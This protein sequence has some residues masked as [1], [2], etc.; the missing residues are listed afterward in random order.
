MIK[1]IP[2]L[3]M[4]I[5]LAMAPLLAQDAVATSEEAAP[6]YRLDPTIDGILLGAAI[7][8]DLVDL[9]LDKVAK[10][11]PL[12]FDASALDLSK[13]N[14]FDRLIMNPYSKEFDYVG[15]GL[16]IVTLLTPALL[17]ATPDEEWLTIGAMYAETLLMA[18]G[19][20][21]LGK[22]CVNR[23]R[24]FMY[25]ADYPQEKVD[26]GDWN[27]SFPSGHTTLA[28]AGAAFTTYV[29]CTYLPDSNMKIPVIASSY[30]LALGTAACRL[31]S[32]NH[33]L[34]DVIVGA[35]LGTLSGLLVPWVHTLNTNTK[36]DSKTGVR[37][38]SV[39]VIPAGILLS[40]KL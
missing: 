26:D 39:Q 32:G 31:A 20:K 19:L 1:K 5:L 21:E 22:I 25:F 12:E 40:F 33:F 3:A 30:V 38:M 35:A 16:E 23:P 6:P 8:L 7:G 28:F 9:Y 4:T 29:F 34:S 27:A 2:L 36:N 14:S 17:L 10:V 18:Y 11:K 24:P 13:V 15:T 37:E